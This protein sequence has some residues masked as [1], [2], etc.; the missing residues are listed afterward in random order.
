MD[1]ETI[2]TCLP[3]SFWLIDKAVKKIIKENNLS[4]NQ[5]EQKVDLLKII[6]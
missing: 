6:V 2:E 4:S 5:E 3:N 1:K